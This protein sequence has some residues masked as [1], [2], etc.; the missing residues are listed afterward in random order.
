MNATDTICAATL[1]NVTV[2]QLTV[3]TNEELKHHAA[4]EYVLI[5]ATLDAI[6]EELRVGVTDIDHKH[7]KQETNRA[8]YVRR[9][10]ESGTLAL[11]NLPRQRRPISTTIVD[12]VQR[13]YDTMINQVQSEL[14][15]ARQRRQTMTAAEREVERQRIEADVAELFN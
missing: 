10:S 12:E 8:E 4:T 15:Q 9:V 6:R 7:F 5:C 11:A 1:L 3:M 2:E 14:D 13:D